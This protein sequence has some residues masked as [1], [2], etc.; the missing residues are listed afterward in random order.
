MKKW[1]ILNDNEKHILKF[2]KLI[3]GKHEFMT[4]KD[5]KT[6]SEGLIKLL[7]GMAHKR[8]GTYAYFEIGDVY[9]EQNDLYWREIRYFEGRSMKSISL[10]T[11]NVGKEITKDMP[12]RN[13]LK[14]YKEQTWN[15]NVY[16]D[17]LKPEEI[18][19][20]IKEGKS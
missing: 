19:I 18:K 4:H 11:W 6:N 12:M 20:L 3:F 9:D 8:G 14:E 1:H 16:F 2:T 10:V 15:A 17:D 5:V 7:I 13:F